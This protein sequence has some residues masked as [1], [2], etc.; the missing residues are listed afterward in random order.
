MTQFNF[1]FGALFVV[2]LLGFTWTYFYKSTEPDQG[3]TACTME[4]K[5]CPDGNTVGRVGPNCE[6]APCP[7]IPEPIV[8][9]DEIQ[10]HIDS[11]ADFIV[12][13]TALRDTV[14]ASPLTVTG[15][16][17]GTW[18]FEASFPIIIVDWDGRIIGQGLGEAQSDW[19]TEDFVPFKATIEFTVATDTPYRRGGI[20]FK[21]DNPSG[22][23]ENDDALEIPV[24]F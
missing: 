14:V 6:F 15:K 13:D 10:I 12:I 20:I 7:I 24:Q 19:M 18:Y 9:A 22:L 1:I 5:I 11:K 21:K 16:A 8:T 3:P 2:A 4:A 17:R 23:P